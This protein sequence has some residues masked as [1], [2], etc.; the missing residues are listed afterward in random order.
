MAHTGD[1]LCQSSFSL[2]TL[3]LNQPEHG[4]GKEHNYPARA[5]R[6]G[7]VS[8]NHVVLFEL[9]SEREEAGGRGALFVD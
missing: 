8:C 4:G 3:D 5:K 9:E 7:G 1:K 6:V 2:Q